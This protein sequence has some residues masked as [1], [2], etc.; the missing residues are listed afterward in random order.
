MNESTNAHKKKSKAK[1]LPEVIDVSWDLSELP[2][3]QHRAGL[4]GLVMMAEFWRG[5]PSKKGVC[6]VV[7]C[8][9]KG[10]TLHVD[11][12]GLQS[13]FDLTYA[14]TTEEV[15]TKQAW[16]NTEPKRTTTVVVRS[17]GK[18]GVVEKEENRFVYD[19]V[20]PAGLLL[21]ELEVG[22]EHERPWL[23]LWRDF[24]WGV[25]RGIPATRGP[26]KERAE[27]IQSDDGEK[28]FSTLASE[29]KSDAPLSSSLYLGAQDSNAEGV[30]FQDVAQQQVLL[31]F[32]TFVTRIYIPSALDKDGKSQFSGFA[33]AIPDV[34]DLRAFVDDVRHDI[35]SRGSKLA[36]FRPAEAVID[37][38]AEAGVD[39]LARLEKRLESVEGGRDVNDLVVGVDVIHCEKEGNNIRTRSVLRIDPKLDLQDEYRRVKGQYW[40]P[41]F[42]RRRIANVLAGAPW[43]TGFAR[44]VETTRFD[45]I[46]DDKKFFCRD[47][48]EA[49]L[50]QGT[51][52]MT[53]QQQ[54]S[55][56]Q[57]V[58]AAT[59]AYVLGKVS[60]KHGLRWADISADGVAKE[61]YG[62]KKSK[63]AKDAFLAVRSRSGADF[64]SYFVSTICSVP[65]HMGQDAYLRLSAELMSA[66]E[67]IRTLT[68]L[69][70]SACG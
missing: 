61:E 1:Q 66:P 70:L 59:Q 27:G 6:S 43:W 36:G 60:S 15:L 40:S 31:H 7:R 4:A 17:E 53:E 68:L 13:L 28:T 10:A 2:S 56:E 55:I 16:A 9:H 49:F 42:R 63:V 11:S 30:G 44:T 22:G 5:W 54:K 29:P 41:I 69:A 64:V 48:R 25:L 35:K 32:W 21:Q 51:T 18:K 67:K 50:E 52:E 19:V 26:Y 37:L 12:V 47:A 39:V 65:Q 58:Y 46:F 34:A 24:V 57:I 20:V 45:H 23:K 33:L 8:D 62:Q 3:S 14:A 38:A